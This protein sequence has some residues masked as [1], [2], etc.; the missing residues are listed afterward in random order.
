M[1]E[2]PRCN[3]CKQPVGDVYFWGRH[4]G[5]WHPRCYA[6]ILHHGIDGAWMVNG[7]LSFDDPAEFT[8]E[9][10]GEASA[11]EQGK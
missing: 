9:L 8:L 6:K 3:E 5:E 11:T 2:P 10:R 7:K 4:G 1:I